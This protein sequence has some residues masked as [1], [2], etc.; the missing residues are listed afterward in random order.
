M[1]ISLGLIICG[2]GFFKPNIST[3]LGNIYNREDLKPIEQAQAYRQLMAAHNWNAKELAEELHVSQGAIS[4]ALSLLSLPADVQAKVDVGA[5]PVTS[6][7]EV[8]K[9][10]DE[11]TQRE[12]LDRVAAESLTRDQVVEVVRETARRE[13]S[14]GRKGRGT[15]PRKVTNRTFRLASGCKVSVE[16]GRGIDP[17]MILAALREATE[18]VEAEMR[19]RG[20]EAA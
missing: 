10:Q 3:L 16:R 8:A 7:Y 9:I 1:Y 20:E 2:N 11:A 12:V 14:G 4:K 13:K 5:L 6:A 15:Q 19:G 17:D 18:V